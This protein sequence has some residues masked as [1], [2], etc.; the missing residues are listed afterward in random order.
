LLVLPAAAA[1]SALPWPVRGALVAATFVLAEASRRWIEDPIRH[2]RVATLR[3]SRSLAVAGAMSLVV[4]GVALGVGRLTAPPQL[5]A[6]VS[7]DVVLDLPTALPTGS[8]AT[9]SPDASATPTADP[10]L[11]PTPAGPVPDDLVPS[12][13]SVRD[14]IPPI[15]AD[16]CHAEWRET[17]PPACVYGREDAPTTVVLIGDSHAAHWFPTFERLARERDW[18]FISLTKS[19]CP[20]ADL[21]VYNTGLKR[22]YVECDDWRAAVL[23][24]IA[25]ERPAMVVISDSR[26][27]QFWVDGTRVA[28]AEREDLWA[29]GLE[30]A[31][32]DIDKVADHVVVMGDTPRPRGDA[33]VCL[34]DHLDDALACATPA[35]KALGPERTATERTVS[36]ET[37]ATFIDPSPWLCPTEPCPAVIGRILV[38]RD[39]HHMTTPFAKA[40]APYVERL[41]P[42][43]PD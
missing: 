28:S 39:G 9:A 10:T 1:G 33:P 27:G 18:R 38:Y 13:A 11:A 15:Y 6:S 23:D 29:T 31:I 4:A 2:G 43:L 21:P 5:A 20:V 30:R 14:D 16:A 25:D 26:T 22:E 3:P 40:L 41:L 8:A 42:D 19:A 7:G 36:A 24:R 35:S 34:S 12:L 17:S 37:G 32:R